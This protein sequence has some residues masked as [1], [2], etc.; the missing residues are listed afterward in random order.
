MADDDDDERRLHARKSMTNCRVPSEPSVRAKAR[1]NREACHFKLS[2]DSTVISVKWKKSGKLFKS[3]EV[4]SYDKE[5]LIST[6]IKDEQQKALEDV[7]ININKIA[8]FKIGLEENEKIERNKLEL[9]YMNK[10]HSG[11]SKVYYEPDIVDDWDDEDPDD[12]LDV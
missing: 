9:P 6:P 2:R 1:N 3:K 4:L 12:D 11:Q 10:I 7:E 8:T 5:N